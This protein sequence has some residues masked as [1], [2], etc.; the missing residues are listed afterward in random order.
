M[1]LIA[2]CDKQALRRKRMQRQEKVCNF[3]GLRLSMAVRGYAV[4]NLI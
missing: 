1:S 2:A 3:V 4:T